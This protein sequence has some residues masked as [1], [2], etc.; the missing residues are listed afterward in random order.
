MMMCAFAP[1]PIIWQALAI[2][3]VS[4]GAQ[5]LRWYVTINPATAYRQAMLRLQTHPGVLEV[6]VC[7]KGCR[8]RRDMGA[9]VRSHVD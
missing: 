5:W 4:M 2:G 8:R 7:W 3:I 6:R 9:C 1:P